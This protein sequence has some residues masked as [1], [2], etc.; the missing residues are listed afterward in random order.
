M[1]FGNHLIQFTNY[2]KMTLSLVKTCTVM[3]FDQNLLYQ[4]IRKGQIDLIT[5]LE[6][7]LMGRQT[8]LEIKVFVLKS[9]V[10]YFS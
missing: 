3:A 5:V 9:D 6:A 7:I 1:S 2:L 8:R 10:K 4:A